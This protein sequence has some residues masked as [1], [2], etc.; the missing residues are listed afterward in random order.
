MIYICPNCYKCVV[1]EESEVRVNFTRYF[2]ECSC[3]MKFVITVPRTAEE[4]L[5][6]WEKVKKELAKSEVE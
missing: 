3:G 1:P 2:Y 6:I 5:V 4:Q